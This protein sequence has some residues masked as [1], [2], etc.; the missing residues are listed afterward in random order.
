MHEIHIYNSKLIFKISEICIVLP[1]WV[2]KHTPFAYINIK[3]HT[4]RNTPCYTKHPL[5]ILIV[6][7]FIFVNSN[8][9]LSM[10]KHH[11]FK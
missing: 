1:I 4:S 11:K 6:K 8:V 2:L 3:I 10:N 9:R 7:K 5:H